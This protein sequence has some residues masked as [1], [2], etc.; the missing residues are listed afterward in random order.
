MATDSGEPT[1]TEESEKPDEVILESRLPSN[2]APSELNMEK[3]SPS[4]AKEATERKRF[5][6]KSVDIV[7]EDQVPE[8][9]VK[10]GKDLAGM[11]IS[12]TDSVSR[13][14][15]ESGQEGKSEQCPKASSEVTKEQSEKEMEEEAEMK[16]VATSPS[17]RFLKF[18]IELGRGAFKTVFKGLD[19]ETWVEVA[20][21]ELQDRKLTKAEQQRF[22]E[23]AEM[24]K[25]LQHPNIVRFYDSW[26]STLKGKK[27]IVLVTELM[28]SGTLK[29]YL[30]RFKVMKPKVLRSWCRQI[31]K[32][33]QFLH[34]R[35]PPIIHRD[36]KCDNIFITGPTGS[37]KIG[38]LGLATLMR[39]SF[40]KSV[41]GTPEFMAPE[42][43][44][45]HYDE[46][47]DV[48]AFGMCMLEMA[49]SEYPY[50]E[51]Q[52][53][54]QIYRKVT[55]GIKPAS[56]DK[57][58]DP[59]VKEIIESC[60]RQNKVERLSI[61]DLLNH[62]FF[63]E[64]TGLR[65]ELA[66]EDDAETPS[67]ALRL[68]VEDPKKL[69]GKHK[70]NEA[71]EFSFNLDI[72]NPEEVACEM[73]KS[74]FF[75]ESDNKAVSKSIRDRV[76][77]IKKMRERRLQADCLGERRD[78]QCRA[79]S[80]MSLTA[81]SHL[82]GTEC[83][84]TEVD[85]HVRQQLLQRLQFN[86]IAADSLSDMGGGS[87][88]LSD[89]SSQEKAIYAIP[90]EHMMASQAVPCV[91]QSE[92]S[93]PGQVYQTQQMLGLYQ[94]SVGHLDTQQ[95]F[96]TDGQTVV[97]AVTLDTSS[98]GIAQPA[99]AAISPQ[100]M[101]AQHSAINLQLD[102]SAIATVPAPASTVEGEQSCSFM[103]IPHPSTTSPYPSSMVSSAQSLPTALAMQ[104]HMLTRPD[105]LL[106]SATPQQ[107]QQSV[108]LQQCSAY[109][110]FYQTP[111][112][113]QQLILQAT[114]AELPQK[115]RQQ[116]PHVQ[117]SS[118]QKHAGVQQ[119]P[120]QQAYTI[121]P[122]VQQ[123]FE[124]PPIQLPPEQQS[125]SKQLPEEKTYAMQ[126]P[127]PHHLEEQAHA[128]QLPIQQPLEQQTYTVQPPVQQSLEQQTYVIQSAVQQPSE[129]QNYTMQP[130]VQQAPEQ[131][132]YTVQPSVHQAPEQQTYNV[133]SPVQ[134][135]PEQ[136]T[137]TVQPSVQQPPEQQTYSMQ[138]PEQQA[139]VIQPLEQQSYMQPPIQ[140]P[141]EKQ[142]Y[143]VQPPEQQ[144][145]VIQSTV[146]QCLEQQTYTMPPHVQQPPEQQACAIQPP[147]QQPL[148]QQAYIIQ[149]IEQT[150]VMQP[151][152]QQPLEQQAYAMHPP[153]QQVPE[154]QSY[155]IHP[156]EQQTYVS[157]TQECKP[158]YVEQQACLAPPLEKQAYAS[159]QTLVEQQVYIVQQSTAEPQQNNQVL[160]Q[161]QPLP[162]MNV[163][164]G[165]VGQQPPSQ[166]YSAQ[167]D[168]QLPLQ[169]TMMSQ[170]APVQAVHNQSLTAF[171]QQ[172]ILYPMPQSILPMGSMT[173][174]VPGQI[175][176]MSLEQPY[177]IQEPPSEQHSLLQS[178]VLLHQQPPVQ[179]VENSGYFPLQLPLP[180]VPQQQWPQPLVQVPTD[181]LLQQ[182]VTYQNLIKEPLNQ[183]ASLNASLQPLVSPPNACA[184]QPLIHQQAQDMQQS[185]QC[186]PQSLTSEQQSTIQKQDSI[187]GDSIN[188]CEQLIGNGKKQRR[189][190]YVR[191]EK[192][193]KFQLT[194]L[195]VS[196][197]GD[198]MVECQLETH[199]NKM[200][201]FKFDADGD[202]PEDIA[203]YMV[204]DDFVLEGEKEKFVEELR[205]IVC[206]S[207]ETLRNLPADERAPGAEPVALESSSSRTGSSEHV[208]INPA[209]TQSS[210]DA[211]PQSSPVGRW[212][213]FIN[214]T[215]KNR[216][217]SPSSPGPQPARVSL[218]KALPGPKRENEMLPRISGA[219]PQREVLISSSETEAKQDSRTEQPSISSQ[220]KDGSEILAASDACVESTN[221]K[222]PLETCASA[223]VLPPPAPLQTERQPNAVTVLP[224]LHHDVAEPSPQP[225]GAALGT[226][227][228][229]QDGDVALIPE[230]N[231][232][233]IAHSPNLETGLLLPSSVQELDAEGPPKIDFV[234]N[235][236]KSLDE[237]LRTLL[238][239]EHSPAGSQTD[240]LKETHSTESPLSSSAE[241]TLSCSIPEPPP[242][243]PGAAQATHE[244]ALECSMTASLIP[245]DVTAC[246]PASVPLLMKDPLIVTANSSDLGSPDSSPDPWL[247]G[248]PE[249]CPRPALSGGAAKLQSGEEAE[250]MKV[251][252]L[253]STPVV[254]Q[255]L[256]SEKGS[257]ES[258]KRGRFQVV[259]VPQ[260][261]EQ[262]DSDVAKSDTQA[263]SEHQSTADMKPL[264]I[265]SSSVPS[266]VTP[267]VTRPEETPHSASTTYETDTS[268]LTP[269][270]E[271][272]GSSTHLG[273]E[274]G[275]QGR[276]RGPC[277][278]QQP[279]NDN[280]M[281]A[282][283]PGLQEPADDC[284]QSPANGGCLQKLNAVFYSPSSPMSSDDES[285]I[286][287]EDLKV[288]LQRLREN[289]NC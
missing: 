247:P 263:G 70:D 91:P 281:A 211:V 113:Q 58:T 26:E 82:G 122:P 19:T 106:Q 283:L 249:A 266:P 40:A 279:S 114:A 50:S 223:A 85:Q 33:L 206:Q 7:E 233:Q 43:Y 257:N 205:I 237:K 124:Q 195:Q 41:I 208:Q 51:C 49:T 197:T 225:M 246:Q 284:D 140:L 253:N 282:P 88:L 126:L 212:R 73:V 287:D 142:A 55:S 191:P 118:V 74:G 278:H 80:D 274:D 6:R 166:A 67:L 3:G 63:A 182:E 18:D 146:Q 168:Q 179:A 190:S 232:L 245:P 145:C 68:W 192:S 258:F 90:P 200:V 188:G 110:P 259:T 25:G 21:C 155:I 104:Q 256:V 109:H 251:D 227:P 255:V 120:E 117:E 64:D 169:E 45:E 176:S 198:N 57:V 15:P 71:I 265:N 60:I 196:T 261:L 187:Q 65:V 167:L 235:R 75:H 204:E 222:E 4:E 213:F 171:W 24:L 242:A 61:R 160:G 79:T 165:S 276:R 10:D 138:P 226:E 130:P 194:V 174:P 173:S 289:S 46:S 159:P 220:A 95:A 254:A 260:Q 23:E 30:K 288:E 164:L 268:S 56:F 219:I 111:L 87:T 123:H 178:T 209:S 271:L 152:V 147:I 132:T 141:L 81:S 149:P 53:A 277:V 89:P 175:Q 151:S 224:D 180:Y 134:Q 273:C 115:E 69:K 62:A 240:S 2:D 128:I 29:T 199:N 136:Q 248:D 177:L 22:K 116:E 105:S 92:T 270:G 99:L 153:K 27:C 158:S 12:R 103:A 144:V 286:E 39:T 97:Q 221:F 78:L 228:V 150:Y 218:E 42:M 93:L 234:D 229:P 186:L 83:E 76:S 72:D 1:S 243:S 100:M 47:V 183:Q 272:T 129:Q 96:G 170:H 189:A 35:T 203:D 48:Y 162:M 17:G 11:S 112:P 135:A 28:T 13:T 216:E 9:S 36:L 77:L 8:P 131:Q 275:L 269:E 16:A 84:D 37:V 267:R 163:T 66:E 156:V 161:Q 119:P 193:T 108:E 236:I 139:Y 280:E 154:H 181:A 238:Y 5:F 244:E 14:T 172:P 262:T 157:Q 54:A 137:Y 44:E 215:I 207:L 98:L 264:D 107:M 133:Q 102:P 101:T 20:W 285:E 32:G 34:T 121:Q 143:T 94:P 214:Q 52:N 252:D 241:D 127:E 230:R 38:D 125:C 86:S 217:V 31:L 239:P 210:S 184:P 250:E 202:A 148:E 201:T 59:E 185:A 231:A